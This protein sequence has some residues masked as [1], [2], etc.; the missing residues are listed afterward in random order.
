MTEKINPVHGWINYILYNTLIFHKINIIWAGKF[1]L[2][3]FFY[4][5]ILFNVY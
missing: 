1:N 5:I 2:Q 3:I 4:F